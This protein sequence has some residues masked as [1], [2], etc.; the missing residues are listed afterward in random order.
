MTGKVAAMIGG[1]TPIS[2]RIRLVETRAGVR[3][4]AP[5]SRAALEIKAELVTRAGARK[6]APVVKVVARAAARVVEAV[7][8]AEALSRLVVDLR[9]ISSPEAGAVGR[10]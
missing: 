7:L 4:A 3:K 6:V 5:G 8:A 10:R 1:R 2:R 9:P